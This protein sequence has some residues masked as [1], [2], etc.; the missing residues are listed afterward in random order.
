MRKKGSEGKVRDFS[1]RLKV[2]KRFL[3]DKIFENWY[4]WTG[5]KEFNNSSEI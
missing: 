3:R 4:I 2:F 1:T 5:I